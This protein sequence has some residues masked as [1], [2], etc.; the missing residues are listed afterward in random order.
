MRT[1]EMQDSILNFQ[2]RKSIGRIVTS[3]AIKLEPVDEDDDVDLGFD[4]GPGAITDERPTLHASSI[5]AIDHNYVTSCLA[6]YLDDADELDSNDDETHIKT[7]PTDADYEDLDATTNSLLSSAILEAVSTSDLLDIV[8]TGTVIESKGSEC[9]V[10]TDR[11]FTKVKPCKLDSS[12]QV[13]SSSSYIWEED[14]DDLDDSEIDLND[15]ASFSSDGNDVDLDGDV[16]HNVD[17]PIDDDI[18]SNIGIAAQKMKIEDINDNEES[19]RG[20]PP[21]KKM[22]LD[23]MCEDPDRL[24]IADYIRNDPKI[25]M[26]P[27]IELDDIVQIILSRG[28]DE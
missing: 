13:S 14:S 22:K 5:S 3:S 1:M 18:T 23:D 8:A 6:P 19:G 26:R 9:R 27:V 25:C 7:E 17:E 2:T 15:T 21:K 11:S 12:D 4:L 10:A 20:L 24:K 28:Y 16:D